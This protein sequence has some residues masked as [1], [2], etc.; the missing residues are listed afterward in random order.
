MNNLPAGCN[1]QDINGAEAYNDTIDVD[2]ESG[3]VFE[4]EVEIVEASLGDWDVTIQ[5]L[6]AK[7]DSRVM[8]I[9][10]LS[11]DDIEEIEEIVQGEIK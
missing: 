11:D 9:S 10:D 7:G 8:H 6:R 3:R 1:I 5:E 2:M 4:V